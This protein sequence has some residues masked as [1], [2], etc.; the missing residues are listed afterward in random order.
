[1]KKIII[2]LLLTVSNNVFSDTSIN[3]KPAIG[4]INQF[5]NQ[6]IISTGLNLQIG[7]QFS[8]D[9]FNLSLI[10]D[11]SITTGYPYGFEYHIGNYFEFDINNIG[12]GFGYYIFGNAFPMIKGEGYGSDFYNLHCI[13]LYTVM[14]NP[15]LNYF[16][17]KLTPY[18]NMYFDTKEKHNDLFKIDEHKFGFGI[19]I[20]LTLKNK[21]NIEKIKI[22]E[23]IIEIEVEHTVEIEVEKPVYIE[24]EKE[25]LIE[26]EPPQLYDVN[27]WFLHYNIDTGT[28]LWIHNPDLTKVRYLP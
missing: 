24:V 20:G 23:K 8:F 17:M 4:I 28:A 21:K 15:Q 19:I 10:G 18:I 3:F 22:T 5:N 13:R 9:K 7:V 25:T 26:I 27:G 16:D 2:I 12:M 1:M 6:N 14:I 11:T